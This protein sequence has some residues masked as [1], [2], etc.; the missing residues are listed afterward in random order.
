MA[1][2]IEFSIFFITINIVEFSEGVELFFQDWRILLLLLLLVIIVILTLVSAKLTSW[3]F[4]FH[5]DK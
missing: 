2:T 3:F 1:W 5:V 4:A